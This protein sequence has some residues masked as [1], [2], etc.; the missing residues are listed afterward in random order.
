MAKSKLSRRITW[1]IISIIMIFNVFIIGAVLYFDF[2]VSEVQSEIRSQH[3]LD[4]L[5]GRLVIMIQTIERISR[6]C[7]AEIEENLDSPEQVAEALKHEILLNEFQGCGMA[8]EPHFFARQGRWFEL[9]T[10]YIDSMHCEIKQ[11]GSEEHDYFNQ[12]W[13]QKGLQQERGKGFMTD[14]YV[15]DEGA[16]H[17]VSTYSQPVFDRQGRKVGVFGMDFYLDWINKAILEEEQII[18]KVEQLDQVLDPYLPDGNSLFIQII[19]SEG[20]KIAGSETFGKEALQAIL[21]VDSIGFEKMKIKDTKYR[22]S[23]KRIKG[24][25]WTLIVAQH[26]DFVFLQ[27]YVIAYFVMFFMIVGAI[28]IFFFTGRSIRRAIA[29]LSYLSDSAQEVA[30][31]HFDTTLPTFKHQD[32]I[33]QLRDSFGTMQQSLKQYVEELRETTAAK[34][35]MESELKVAHHIQMSMLPTSFPKREG[36]DLYAEMTPAKAVGGDLFSYVMQGDHLYICVG[37]VSG[38][39]VPASLFMSQTTR[40][41]NTFAKEGMMPAD[42]A[43]R[44]N[45]E[46][47]ENNDRCVFVTMFIGL[48]DLTSGSLD[49]CNCGHCPPVV[50]GAFLK[51]TYKNKP[52][53]LMGDLPFEGEHIDNIRGRQILIY[54]DGLTEAMNPEMVLFGD[55]RLLQQMATIQGCTARETIHQLNEAIS[56]HRDGAETNDDL[57][58]MGLRIT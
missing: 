6:N 1:R 37:D 51:L 30:Q 57:T 44:I 32:E 52:L 53:G 56:Q 54:T 26:V 39:G 23:S 42:I 50:D 22:V 9:Y 49:F 38:K 2:R 15:D 36:L 4:R 55:D 35:S 27:G 10:S 24:T 8:F 21:K 33:S 45:N 28:V 12:E 48:I 14:P 11:I 43:F 18:K 5:D 13:Y 41:F 25:D 46:L 3:L 7:V 17:I 29:P 34:A 19:D 20:N 47:S 40:L 58:M 16:R 31:G